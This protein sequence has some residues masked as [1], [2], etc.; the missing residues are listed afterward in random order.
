MNWIEITITKKKRKEKKNTRYSQHILL[1]K[2]KI[3]SSSRNSLLHWELAWGSSR[4]QVGWVVEWCWSGSGSWS[5]L[6]SPMP[7]SDER[8]A[9][10]WVTWIFYCSLEFSSGVTN[11]FSYWI[12]ALDKPE[13]WI[14]VTLDTKKAKISNKIVAT[15]SNTSNQER[16]RS[17]KVK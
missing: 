6:N 2:I 13:M 15:P 9:C 17:K 3:S 1:T 10:K 4:L 14:G 16:A 11:G 5:R 8:T 12:A 7:R